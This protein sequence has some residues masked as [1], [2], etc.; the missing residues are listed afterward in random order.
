MS[1]EQDIDTFPC[2]WRWPSCHRNTCPR[3]LASKPSLSSACSAGE[4]FF[5]EQDMFKNRY[6]T[7]Y[8]WLLLSTW[9][10]RRTTSI[11]AWVESAVLRSLGSE[12]WQERIIWFW[13]QKIKKLN[14]KVFLILE[15]K[16]KIRDVVTRIMRKNGV[17]II[18]AK[19]SHE[20]S[21]Q[22]RLQRDSCHMIMN[23]ISI[24]NLIECCSS[25]WKERLW[26]VGWPLTCTAIPCRSQQIANLQKPR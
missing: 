18:A 19:S 21:H 25:P 14:T 1:R 11:A 9:K 8:R 15:V 12:K 16:L 10:K 17:E 24:V 5:N 22:S 4:R 23:V 13:I 7:R 20:S 6:K 26:I 2:R 3:S